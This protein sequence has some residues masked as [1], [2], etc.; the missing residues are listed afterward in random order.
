MGLRKPLSSAFVHAESRAQRRVEPGFVPSAHGGEEDYVVSREL[1]A[2]RKTK[3]VV[4]RLERLRS[5]LAR[6]LAE[7]ARRVAA[8][9][10][11]M[12]G[13]LPEDLRAGPPPDHADFQLDR[14]PLL[15][16]LLPKFGHREPNPSSPEERAYHT[17]RLAWEE[18]KRREDAALASLQ[19]AANERAAARDRRIV[20]MERGGPEVLEQAL[21]AVL[22]E[23]A[24]TLELPG[25]ASITIDGQKGAARIDGRAP[26]IDE[27]VPSTARYRYAKGR[28]AVVAVRFSDDKRGPL[29]RRVLAQM[30][31]LIMEAAFADTPASV[32]DEVGVRLHAEAVDPTTGRMART[33]LLRVEARREVFAALDLTRVDPIPCVQ[34]LAAGAAFP[35]SDPNG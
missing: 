23:L 14:P 33:E 29:Y 28:D 10:P 3:A 21:K 22:D 34:R 2:E 31:L 20:E 35:R 17:A 8:D 7:R 19:A 13:D 4:D 5:V 27:V 1:E 25:P 18:A 9:R 15:G 11:P 6:G 12:V 24:P 26:M 32:L 30:A 16:A